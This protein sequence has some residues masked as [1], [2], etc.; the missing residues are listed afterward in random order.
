M[1]DAVIVTVYTNV[2]KC[3]IEYDRI[4][5]LIATQSDLEVGPCIILT[6]LTGITRRLATANR[7]RVSIRGKPCRNFHHN[8]ILCSP[9]KIRLLFLILS[10]HM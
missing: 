8:Y 9:S 2:Y 4:Q 10:A 3:T 7:S 5:N 6:P 1:I